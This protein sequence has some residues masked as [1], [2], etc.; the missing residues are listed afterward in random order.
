[1][2]H[3]DAIFSATKTASKL[4]EKQDVLGTIEKG[5]FADIIAVSGNPL[6]KVEVLEEVVFFIKNGEIYKNLTK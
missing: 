2:S 1:M 3:T 6:Q 4:I 5:K